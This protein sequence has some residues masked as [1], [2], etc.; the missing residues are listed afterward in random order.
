MEVK[1]LTPGSYNLGVQVSRKTTRH[2]AFHAPSE[3]PSIQG[4]Q[5]VLIFL[6]HG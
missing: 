3:V 6:N 5:V 4:V 1:N 2:R